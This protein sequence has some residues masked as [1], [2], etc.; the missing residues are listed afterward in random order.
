MPGDMGELTGHARGTVVRGEW[1]EQVLAMLPD[2][3]WDYDDEYLTGGPAMG[4]TPVLVST[5]VPMAA[6]RR[7][8]G[9]MIGQMMRGPVWSD[10]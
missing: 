3:V 7:I 5:T 1:I 9:A 8:I 6:R 4:Y 2:A 10:E